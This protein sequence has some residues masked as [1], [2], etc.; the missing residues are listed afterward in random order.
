MGVVSTCQRASVSTVCT[1][2]SANSTSSAAISAVRLRAFWPSQP[3]RP[4]HQPSP[5][6]TVSRL[7][8]ASSPVTS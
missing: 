2:P 1:R 7:S 3:M 5:T 6:I 8:G 4:P